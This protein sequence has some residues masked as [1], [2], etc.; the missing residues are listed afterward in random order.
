MPRENFWRR[1]DV[2]SRR[3]LARVR[4]VLREPRKA[5]RWLR[6]PRVNFVDVPL[7]VLEALLPS[8]AVILDAGAADGT[9]ALALAKS[10]PNGRLLA[11]EPHPALFQMCFER[12][13]SARNV[14][15]FQ[16]ALSDHEGQAVLN[17]SSGPGDSS[18]LLRPHLHSSLHPEIE[19]KSS[20]SVRCTTI[21]QFIKS[22]KLPWPDMLRLDLQGVELRVLK[23]SP[24]ALAS[25]SLI[26]VEASRYPL[27]DGGAVVDDLQD[28]MRQEGF[29]LI[30]DRM[31]AFTGNLLFGRRKRDV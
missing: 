19:F 26:Q 7:Q 11:V 30:L 17:L 3:T 25:S 1:R 28:F 8:N 23:S 22:R 18:S 6:E 16:L 2:A 20:V 21:D 29:S 10:F 5:L 27:F 9:D 31:G 14:E 4:L 15:C 13:T 12:A 24:D